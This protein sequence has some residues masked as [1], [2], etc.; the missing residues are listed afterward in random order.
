[1]FKISICD[2]IYGCRPSCVHFHGQTISKCPVQMNAVPKIF[3]RT[4]NIY[5]DLISIAN[6]CKSHWIWW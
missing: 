3:A 2:L 4:Q 1:M 6:K 5:F